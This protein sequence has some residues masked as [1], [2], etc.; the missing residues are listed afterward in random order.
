MD[1]PQVSSPGLYSEMQQLG[2]RI[3][4][5]IVSEPSTPCSTEFIVEQLA[6]VEGPVNVYCWYEGP[7]CLPA[8]G[9]KYL[10]EK[11]FAPLYRLKPAAQLYLYSLNGWDFEKNVADMQPE[12]LLGERIN[13][14]NDTAIACLYSSSFFRYC[15]QS[16]QKSPLYQYASQKLPEKNWLI[17][18]SKE[19]KKTNK[20][21]AAFFNNQSTLFDCVKDIDVSEAY[22]TM[23]YVEAYYLIRQ[24]VERGLLKQERKIEI[25]FVL[26]NDESKYYKD[27]PEDIEEM[28]KLDFGMALMGKEISIKFYCFKYGNAAK[29]RPYLTSR[30]A[31]AKVQPENVLEYFSYLPR[32]LYT[33]EIPT[34]C[35]LRDVIHRL[36]D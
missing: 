29:R 25:A 4:L 1:V 28:L 36:N 2:T 34:G 33:Y 22:A 13:S 5:Q 35:I 14:I 21:V 31:D 8:A 19:Y 6:K 12:T 9:A 3:T 24:A 7:E 27:L 16:A 23:Q 15:V 18:L 32:P 30:K 10:T 20:T 17:E 11:I 26:P